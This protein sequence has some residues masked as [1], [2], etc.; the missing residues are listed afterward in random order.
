[1]AGYGGW[2]GKIL[3]VDLSKVAIGVE[4]DTTKQLTAFDVP[5]GGLSK[6]DTIEIQRLYRRFGPRF[7]GLVG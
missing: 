4:V 5:Y 1:M 7:K 6:V 2:T 3:R